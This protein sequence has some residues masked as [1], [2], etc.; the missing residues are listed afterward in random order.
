MRKVSL[1][2]IAVQAGVS[3]TTVSFVI[4]G[5]AREMRVSGDVIQRIETLI[6]ELDYQP[7]AMARG[8]RTG[9]TGTI[10]LMVEDISNHFFATLARSI[11]DEA[12]CFGY[13][14]IYCSTENKEA[15][16]QKLLE[17]LTRRQVDG[18]ILTPT[19]DLDTGVQKLLREKKSLVLMDRYFPSLNTNFVGVDNFLGASMA[20]AHLLAKGYKKI[21]LVT[22]SSSQVQMMERVQGFTNTVN[23]SDKSLI[24]QIPLCIPFEKVEEDVIEQIIQFLIKHK[25]DAVFFT[26]NYLGICGLEAIKKLAWAIPSQIGVVIFDDHIVFRLYNPAITCIA[27]PI[28]EIGKYAVRALIQDIQKKNPKV[29]ARYILKPQLIVR[30][31]C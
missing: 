26:T 5:K 25:P 31:S 4:N 9:R 23:K 6:K 7:N 11:E 12:D 20:T 14:V 27:Q 8:L 21:A 13:D 28:M 19:P 17:T 10:G 24:K 22:T 15:R 2:D 18:Y 29:S 3:P 30:E 1:R 16:A